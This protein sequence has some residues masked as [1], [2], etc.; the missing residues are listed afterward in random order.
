VNSPL[1]PGRKLT[2]IAGISMLVLAG[3][4]SSLA[5]NDWLLYASMQPVGNLASVTLMGRTQPV[6]VELDCDYFLKSLDQVRV[7][8]YRLSGN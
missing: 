8:I 6:N 7:F 2:N 3:L 1:T 5:R 4:A